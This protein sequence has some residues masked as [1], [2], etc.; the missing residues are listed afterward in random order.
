M[1][2]YTHQE[3]FN[4]IWEHARKGVKS[5]SASGACKYRGPDGARCFIGELIPDERYFKEMDQT[6]IYFEGVLDRAAVAVDASPEAVG[7]IQSIHDHY[8]PEE[9]KARLVIY[10]SNHG[11]TVPA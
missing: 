11:L 6:I 9:W 10:A 1:I 5:V 7:E 3:A 4:I 2:T 8:Q